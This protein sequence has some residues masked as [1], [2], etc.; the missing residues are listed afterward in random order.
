MVNALMKRELAVRLVLLFFSLVLPSLLLAHSTWF[1]PRDDY[2]DQGITGPFAAIEDGRSITG[3]VRY[4][5]GPKL[6]FV[7]AGQPYTW[8]SSLCLRENTYM[9]GEASLIRLRDD[10]EFPGGKVLWS[11]SDHRCGP[12]VGSAVAPALSALDGDETEF[13]LK[14]RATVRPTSWFPL[15]AP[16]T[17]LTFSVHRAPAADPGPAPAPAGSE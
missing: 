7:V 16:L 11:P 8:I 1:D 14:R 6:D 3:A 15:N 2:T 10:F 4:K 5:T 9:L 12:F 17:S 13:E